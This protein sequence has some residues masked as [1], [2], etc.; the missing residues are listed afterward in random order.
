MAVAVDGR[1][2]A[3]V[4]PNESIPALPGD[5]QLDCRGRLV[6][7]GF[8]D[9]HAQLVGGA[10]APW[11]PDTTAK[12]FLARLH[13]EVDIGKT[14][15]AAEVGALT[16]HA[17]ARN[18][19]AG[20][21]L[22]VDSVM[23]FE[24]VESALEAQAQAA[25]QLGSRLIH[26]HAS[27]SLYD[28]FSPVAQVEANAH[29]A[30]KYKT[31][32]LIRGAL[33][34]GSSSGSSDELL[35]AVG[36]L[37]EQTGLS[38]HFRMAQ[39]DDDVQM[40]RDEYQSTVFSRFERF[41]LLGAGAVAA[42]LLALGR[43]EA[44]RLAQS[45]TLLALCPREAQWRAGAHAIGLE[46]V[47]SPD[48]LVA[49][50]SNG[51]GSLREEAAACMSS[52][53]ALSVAGRFLDVDAALSDYLFG[54]AAQ[55]VSMNFGQAIGAVEPGALADFVVFDWVPPSV[56]SSPAP[57]VIQGLLRAPIA[58]TV[59]NGRVVV[60]DGQLVGFDFVELATEAA[61]ATTA[62]CKRLGLT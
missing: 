31:H 10:L 54:G 47:L 59:V 46:G 24:C 33:G 48:N 40:T 57:Q 51:S 4:A 35:R 26:S 41:G 58:H 23:A 5:W 37:K 39:G 55:M 14:V 22:S 34:C 53:L 15:T 21:T 49:L 16:A 25:E 3:N 36:R 50:G 28:S 18:L 38:C 32:Q 56:G 1:L 52:L 44:R 11:L 60:R 45:R 7:P 2:I 12:P 9:C 6:G 8:F 13:D 61:A 43:E 27:S 17:L 62:I 20:V 30:S 29:V 19:R 42:H